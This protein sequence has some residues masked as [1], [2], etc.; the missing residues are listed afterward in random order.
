MA[1]IRKCARD[2]KKNKVKNTVIKFYT[3]SQEAMR[4]LE[5]PI[6]SSSLVRDVKKTL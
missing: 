6:T 2:L 3:D 4:A 5:N 1:A